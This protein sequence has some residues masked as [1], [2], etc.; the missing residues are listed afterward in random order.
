MKNHIKVDGKLLQTNKKWSHLKNSQRSWISE[1]TKEEH[2]A[3]VAEHGRLP[4][5]KRKEDVLDRVHERV[6]GRDIWIPY[7]EFKSHVNVY[8]DRL[9]HKSPLFTPPKKKPAVQKPKTLRGN[10]E[11]FPLEVQEDMK[12]S[13]AAGVKRYIGQAHRVPPNKGYISHRNIFLFFKITK[14]RRS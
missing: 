13:I 14:A 5:K 10:F 1:V 9:N 3:Y 11:E 4:M 8:I 6:V 2:T 7:H 12:K